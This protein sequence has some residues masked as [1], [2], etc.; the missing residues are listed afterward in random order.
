M[1]SNHMLYVSSVFSLVVSLAM[2]VAVL[3][4][5][6]LASSHKGLRTLNII[7]GIALIVFSFPEMQRL[8]IFVYASVFLHWITRRNIYLVL[9]SCAITF[10]I[11][12]KFS[13][14]AAALSLWIPYLAL[15]YYRERKLQIIYMALMSLVVSYLVVWLMMYGSLS[16]AFGYL[17]GEFYI[18]SGNASAMAMNPENNWLAI[19]TFYI[20]CVLSAAV[21]YFYSDHR[22][23]VLPLMFVLP[24][25]V[26]TKYSFSQ[27]QA[28]HFVPLLAFAVYVIS[29]FIIAAPKLSQ[30]IALSVLMTCSGFAWK[31]MHTESVGSPDYDNIPHLAINQPEVVQYQFNFNE[32]F[33]IWRTAEIDRLAILR[34]PEDI[35]IKIGKNS[36]DVY[37][38]ELG[39]ASANKLNW[40][41]RP[42][43]QTYVDY[44]PF[45]D[46][47]NY[48]FYSGEKAPQ[49]IVWH[50]HE[51]QDVM[52]RY[53]LSS[54]PMTTESILRHYRLVQCE[55]IFCL[56]K[57]AEQDQ[58][59]SVANMDIQTARW[60]EW[61][62]VPRK[63][64]LA[65]QELTG[66]G[67]VIRARLFAKRTL[68]GK[69]N[70]FVWK[71]GGI[72]VDYKLSSG[73]I[74]SHDL[75]IDNAVSGV[76]ISPYV[77]QY[78]G[79]TSAKPEEISRSQLNKILMRPSVQG[80]VDRIEPTLMGQ[81]L[82]GWASAPSMM[83]TQQYVLLFNHDKSFLVPAE[84]YDRSDVVDYFKSR[85]QTVT[86]RCGYYEEIADQQ[87]PDGEY[88]VRL[89]VKY[90]DDKGL[91]QWGAIPD[92]GLIWRVNSAAKN[93]QV[94]EVRFRTTRPWAFAEK[95]NMQWQKLVYTSA[96][97]KSAE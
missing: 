3:H 38:W 42:V 74:K 40:H 88:K 92:Q 37:P 19:V 67:N 61:I 32:L 51:F 22:Y 50:H 10:C 25:F 36:V 9:L 60:N 91:D 48:D 70:L 62:T 44:L 95:M 52:N 89:V 2:N 4:L 66:Y 8:L 17:Q 82:V 28:L 41:P 57:H 18:S 5:A 97:T 7:F 85:G 79:R 29:I 87:L 71:E 72:E 53:S 73:V 58:L 20:A 6:W 64:L 69:L 81:R 24:L 59:Q 63:Q 30:K 77:D 15:L 23:S 31:A 78:L 54:E 56:W 12:I 75:L 93:N 26:W 68:L 1:V 80:Y 43:F 46:R 47:K 35:R 16:G 21:I 55:G 96:P 86:G 65:D 83:D 14:G 84:K 76:W 11:F 34:L 27:E 49:F 45:L 94:A 90:K 13:Y 39:I 33:D